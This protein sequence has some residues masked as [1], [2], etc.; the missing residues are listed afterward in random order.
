MVE[1]P[2]VPGRVRPIMDTR[3]GCGQTELCME[4]G[5][6]AASIAAVS[7]QSGVIVQMDDG[8]GSVDWGVVQ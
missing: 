3:V 4:K 2:K 6:R 1:T 5:V 7:D 8:R